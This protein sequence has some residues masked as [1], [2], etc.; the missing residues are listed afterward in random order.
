MIRRISL[1]IGVAVVAMAV[2]VP[3]ALGDGNKGRFARSPAPMSAVEYFRANE[4]ATLAQ[5]GESALTG[6]RDA[7]E[8]GSVAGNQPGVATYRDAFERRHVARTGLESNV[9]SYR[10]AFERANPSSVPV[11]TS[12]VSGT[13]IEWPQVGIGLGLGIM[14]ALGL[15]LAMRITRIRPLAH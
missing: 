5:S 11:A 4:L 6:Y 12:P 14:L 13:E 7:F 9:G 1:T 15:W 8:R 3:T 10:D 2:G